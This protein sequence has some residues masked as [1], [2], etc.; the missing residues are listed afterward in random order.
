MSDP[1]YRCVKC[2]EEFENCTCKKLN[3]EMNIKE[4]NSLLKK[5]L[6]LVINILPNHSAGCYGL[7]VHPGNCRRCCDCD[8]DELRKMASELAKDV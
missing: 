8:M 6:L 3:K 5:I 1:T 7:K 4:Q 2:N